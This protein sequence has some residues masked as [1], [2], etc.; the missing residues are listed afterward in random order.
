M[1]VPPSMLEEEVVDRLPPCLFVRESLLEVVFLI[2]SFNV[3]AKG[4]DLE[5][6]LLE[7]MMGSSAFSSHSFKCVPA[8][9][10]DHG[11]H[12][13]K[14]IGPALRKFSLWS[15]FSVVMLLC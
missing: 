7:I 13:S 3:E 14:S 9:A 10:A 11:S 1:E 6:R 12:V 15:F 4:C 8:S 2:N 5:G